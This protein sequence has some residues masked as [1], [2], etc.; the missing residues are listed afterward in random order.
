MEGET[1]TTRLDSNRSNSELLEDISRNRLWGYFD[2]AVDGSF[3]LGSASAKPSETNREDA[4][5]A[6]RQFIEK[7][8]RTNA[9]GG[10]DSDL[11][12]QSD[13]KL[14]IFFFK[15]RF[16]RKDSDFDL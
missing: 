11:L 9:L 5:A 13:T 2:D 16:R 6:V 12:Q 10:S 8:E 14:N 1:F 3:Y 15:N 7:A 4:R